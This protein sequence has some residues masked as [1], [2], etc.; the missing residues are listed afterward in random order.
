[1]FR[2]WPHHITP[3]WLVAALAAA[4]LVGCAP[5]ASPV[6]AAGSSYTFSDTV[7]E[8]V[9]RTDVPSRMDA[10]TAPVSRCWLWFTLPQGCPP[11]IQLD[12]RIRPT[13][14]KS[15]VLRPIEQAGPGVTA[16]VWIVSGANQPLAKAHDLS[17]K[18][19]PRLIYV[20]DGRAIEDFGFDV[21]PAHILR[22]LG[23]QAAMATAI[24][25]V[26]PEGQL[27]FVPLAPPV[28]FSRDG[29][30]LRFSKIDAKVT[31]SGS[32]VKVK[33][34]DPRPIVS[35]RIWGFRVSDT[36]DET[37]ISPAGV[38]MLTYRWKSK[39]TIKWD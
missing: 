32:T 39:R 30:E 28:V 29:N 8:P 1:M 20:E 34:A 18:G 21:D 27:M 9:G 17:R 26:A 35:G 37:T 36:L 11:C 24:D 3:N 7:P 15:L 6:S 12:R 25:F 10:P 22:R 14:E 13:L 31:S 2:S 38:D 4:G 5:A 33:F 16:N 23:H 19:W